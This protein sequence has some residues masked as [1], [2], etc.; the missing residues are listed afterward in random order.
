MPKTELRF[1][2]GG[3]LIHLLHLLLVLAMQ[4]PIY[5]LARLIP[6]GMEVRH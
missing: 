2:M 4:P 5:L 6:R 3:R 1:S